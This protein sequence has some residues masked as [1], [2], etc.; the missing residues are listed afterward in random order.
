MLDLADAVAI[1]KFD[2]RGADDALRQVRRQWVRD[3]GLAPEDTEPVFG[4]IA[5]R[6]NDDGVTALYQHLRDRLSGMGLVTVPGVL[7]VIGGRASTKA[8]VIIPGPRRRYLAEI[9]ETVH[10]YHATT[11]RAGGRSP[12]VP[13]VRPRCW[14]WPSPRDRP[15]ATWARLAERIGIG[16]GPGG[17]TA[18]RGVGRAAHIA[19]SGRSRGCLVSR[20]R[21]T[22]SCGGRRCRGTASPR[23]PCPG[24]PSTGSWCG[25]SGRS[26]SPATFPSPPACSPSSVRARTR[27]ACSPARA[28]PSAPTVGSISSRRGSPATRLSTAFDSVTLYGFD[29]DERPDI[30]GKIG[31]SGVS[32]ATLDDMKVLFDGIDLCDPATSVSMTINGPA[33]TILAMFL[34]T[35]IDQRL[36]LFEAEHGRPADGRAS[37]RP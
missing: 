31:T 3:H 11:G 35:A 1:N 18:P 6:F 10:R 32:I 24:S 2:R 17:P 33:P 15:S 29:P 8:S 7:P 14:P 16:P 28:T 22:Q 12:P 9:T 37:A 21:P 4:T 23:W 20:A 36:D 19:D 27:P 34:C 25:G 5:S 30:Y 13:A 26:T